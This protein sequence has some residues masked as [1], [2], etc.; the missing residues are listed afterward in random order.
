[1]K[2]RHASRWNGPSDADY[3]EAARRLFQI[4]G[5]VE[6]DAFAKVSRGDA[7]G[8]Y[9]EAWV[10]VPRSHAQGETES[11]VATP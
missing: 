11:G 3:M 2:K 5:Q 10:Y 6:I 4:D 1:M 8:A 7:Q 9:V